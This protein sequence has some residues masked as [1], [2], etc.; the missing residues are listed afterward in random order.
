MESFVTVH[1]FLPFSSLLPL[2]SGGIEMV[3]CTLPSLDVHDISFC[4][5]I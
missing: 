5:F 3:L 1:A 2:G 4:I